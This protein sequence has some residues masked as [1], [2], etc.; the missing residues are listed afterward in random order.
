MRFFFEVLICIII[1]A[2][3][4]LSSAAMCMLK[5]AFFIKAVYTVFILA[6]MVLICIGVVSLLEQPHKKN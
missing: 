4:L 6:A 3:G 2:A 1:C 5:I